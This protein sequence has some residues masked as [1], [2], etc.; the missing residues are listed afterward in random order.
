M[1][2]LGNKYKNS[3]PVGLGMGSNSLYLNVGFCYKSSGY[4]SMPTITTKKM[5]RRRS[6]ESRSLTF[7]FLAIFIILNPTLI[8]IMQHF[9]LSQLI[10]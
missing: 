6:G 7:I 8:V 1:R 10:F 3:W 5:W 4:K 2:E 9:P